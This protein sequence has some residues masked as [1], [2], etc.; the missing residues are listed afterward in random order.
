MFKTVASRIRAFL[1]GTLLL[2][3]PFCESGCIPEDVCQQIEDFL[4]GLGGNFPLD[5]L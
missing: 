2:T 5:L 3:L 1:G 4:T